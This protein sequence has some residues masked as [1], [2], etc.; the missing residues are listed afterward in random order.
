MVSYEQYEKALT[1]LESLIVIYLETRASFLWMAAF[2][3]QKPV[4]G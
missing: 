4:K 3:K 1:I 2:L